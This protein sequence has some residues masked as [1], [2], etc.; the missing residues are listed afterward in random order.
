M[1]VY[2]T[3]HTKTIGDSV[4]FLPIYAT[5]GGPVEAVIDDIKVYRVSTHALNLEEDYSDITENSMINYISD[6]NP[7]VQLAEL[8]KT[9]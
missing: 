2:N 6:S 4:K 5:G 7:F 9:T 8:I 3:S 1:L